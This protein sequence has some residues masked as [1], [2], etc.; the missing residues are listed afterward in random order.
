MTSTLSIENFIQNFVTCCHLGRLSGKLN[1]TYK[2]NQGP[3]I[4]RD[5]AILNLIQLNQME[6]NHVRLSAVGFMNIF[7]HVLSVTCSGQA[8]YFLMKTPGQSVPPILVDL[9][10]SENDESTESSVIQ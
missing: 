10:G 6:Q 8:I 2:K 5:I 3:G 7:S 4:L 9:A 1:I